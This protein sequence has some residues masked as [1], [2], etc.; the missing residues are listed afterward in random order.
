MLAT[1]T[2]RDLYDPPCG[3]KGHRYL[4]AYTALDTVLHRHGYAPRAGVT[5]AYNCRKITGG[6]GYSLHAYG[7]GAL[8]TFWSGV[9]V[10]TSLAV[11]INWDTNPYGPRL[12]TDMPRAMIDDITRIRTR[13]GAQVWRWGGYYRG[14]KDAMH[15]EIVCHPDDLATGIDPTTIR[16]PAADPI[17][18]EDDDMIGAAIDAALEEAGWTPSRQRGQARAKWIDE[19][20][21][22]QAAGGDPWDAVRTLRHQLG[23]PVEPTW[24]G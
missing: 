24:P 4:A 11:D 7:V 10:A 12:V 22:K 21:K 3:H 17:H 5:G 14:N 15:F 8:F 18:Q 1:S 16:G 13:S 9:R 2:L 19:A 6:S 20:H 23:L